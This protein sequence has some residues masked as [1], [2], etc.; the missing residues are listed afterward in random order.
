MKK[1]IKFICL[2]L[3]FSIGLFP[4][5][6]CQEKNNVPESN[7]VKI[8]D[9]VNFTITKKET[10]LP[11]S[12]VNLRAFSSDVMPIGGFWGPFDRDP[13]NN[14]SADIIDGI[15]IPNFLTDEYFQ[16]MK[17]AEINLIYATG[18][19]YG[20][21]GFVETLDLAS[22]YNMGMYALDGR[23]ASL[24]PTSQFYGGVDTWDKEPNISSV[25]LEQYVSSYINHPALTGLYLVDEPFADQYK[26]MGKV[27]DVFYN[28]CKYDGIQLG[29]IF[30]GHNTSNRWGGYSY[31]EELDGFI[32]NCNPNYL[33][34]DCYIF[35][36][37]SKDLITPAYEYYLDVLST[38]YNTAKEQSIPFWGVMQAGGDWTRL[39]DDSVK[40]DRQFRPTEGQFLWNYNTMLCYGAK[41]IIFFPLFQPYAYTAEYYGTNYDSSGI[42]GADGGKNQWY[43]YAQKQNKH[44]RACQNVLMNSE[45]AGLIISGEIANSMFRIRQADDSYRNGFFKEIIKEGSFRQLKKVYGEALI[46]CFDYNGST[47]LY[48]TNMS[49]DNKNKITLEFDDTY[50]YD[51]IQRGSLSSVAGSV[52]TLTLEAGEGALVTLR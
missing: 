43:F 4:L 31:Q 39:T 12:K 45:S 27:Y 7:V 20:Q 37:A 17:D 48:I 40:L 16:Y 11:V 34:F 5:F 19:Y 50:A 3:S 25:E 9:N 49:T 36:D 14:S 10:P 30:V 1:C 15:E 23:I 33:S 32:K 6:S 41:G 22:K 51:I 2:L 47:A 26:G 21:S 35:D 13:N 42:F 44:V 18:K 52:M 24:V 46:G 38:T 29:S 8:S 28:Q